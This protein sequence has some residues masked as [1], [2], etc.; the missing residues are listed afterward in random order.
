MSAIEIL[1]ITENVR[2][3]LNRFPQTRRSDKSL[4]W[5]YWKEYD[6]I[7]NGNGLD[8]TISF[9]DFVG[10]TGHE[11]ITRAARKVRE[12]DE[13]LK[14]NPSVEQCKRDIE[15]VLHSELGKPSSLFEK[16]IE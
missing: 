16:G 3:I 12:E 11:S 14:S 8:S 9:N 10:A 1:S 5:R 4:V 13:T 15:R 2:D 6:G 7:V